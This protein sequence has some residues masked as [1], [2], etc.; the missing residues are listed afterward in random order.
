M[1]LQLF[2][3]R[4]AARAASA[5]V[6]PGRVALSDPLCHVNLVVS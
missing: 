5:V 4:G 3:T 2:T 1:G 6:V